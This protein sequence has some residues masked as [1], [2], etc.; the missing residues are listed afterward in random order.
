MKNKVLNQPQGIIDHESDAKI[1]RFGTYSR[2]SSSCVDFAL[3]WQGH[4]N[5]TNPRLDWILG[6]IGWARNA[7]NNPTLEILRRDSILET[8]RVISISL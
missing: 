6:A 3:G 8:A 7:R 2:N 4:T 1:L 5:L